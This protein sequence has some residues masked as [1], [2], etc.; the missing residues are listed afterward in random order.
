MPRLCSKTLA[1]LSC[2]ALYR[3]THTLLYFDTMYL[4]TYPKDNSINPFRR[5]RSLDWASLAA[6]H[7]GND[8]VIMDISKGSAK[9]FHD[10]GFTTSDD[11]S[12]L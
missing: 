10:H 4:Y 1:A 6:Y 9:A 12:F 5:Y 3:D 2:E 8:C 11:S 7:S